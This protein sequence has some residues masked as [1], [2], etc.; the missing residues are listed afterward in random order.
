[1]GQ[2]VDGPVPP[3]PQTIVQ[4]RYHRETKREKQRCTGKPVVDWRGGGLYLVTED[5]SGPYE[6]KNPWIKYFTSSAPFIISGNL[7]YIMSCDEV[8][9]DHKDGPIPSGLCDIR[10]K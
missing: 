7:Y 10:Y 5:L 3:C 2:F 8:R 9:I 6:M 4:L 1:L